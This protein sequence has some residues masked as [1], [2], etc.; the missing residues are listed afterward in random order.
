MTKSGWDL[1][2]RKECIKSIDACLT[3]FAIVW[4]RD[5]SSITNEAHVE[6]ISKK[7]R[8]CIETQEIQDVYQVTSMRECIKKLN[9]LTDRKVILVISLDD[10]LSDEQKAGL[11]SFSHVEY[12][13]QFGSEFPYIKLNDI[14]NDDGEV[15]Q[16]E[17]CLNNISFD[18]TS[19]SLE[20]FDRPTKIFALKHILLELLQQTPC[21]EAEKRD[22]VNFCLTKCRDEIDREDID[23]YANAYL[24]YKA[25]RWYS[26]ETLIPRTINRTL[27][28]ENFNSIIR[29]HY[30]IHDLYSE[31]YQLYRLQQP[32]LFS[33]IQ[34][35]RGKVLTR[36]EL[37][38]LRK[39]VGRYVVTNSFVSTST[40]WI[41]ANVFSGDGITQLD[42]KVSVIFSI[43]LHVKNNISKPL[44]YIGQYSQKAH[45]EEEVLLSSGILMRII[46]VEKDEV[47][48]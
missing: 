19:R 26:G 1:D 29:I 31:L 40:D 33:G 15:L 37:E 41:V 35:F 48:V 23:K 38:R 36:N 43:Q 14:Y 44:A 3:K 21:T 34:L 47:C 5:L 6:E 46:S 45:H 24:E 4:L 30:F 18:I 12:I 9:K 32:C 8:L 39:S 22:F 17:S 42:D 16:N 10:P 28:E 27:R 11:C 13:Y 20:N 25:I 2:F 7:L